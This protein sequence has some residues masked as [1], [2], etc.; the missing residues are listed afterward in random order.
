MNKVIPTA[1]LEAYPMNR[2]IKIG[3]IGDFDPKKLS[4]ITNER[5]FD[6]CRSIFVRCSGVFLAYDSVVGQGA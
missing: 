4:H 1:H 2:K 6:P 5:V 3:I